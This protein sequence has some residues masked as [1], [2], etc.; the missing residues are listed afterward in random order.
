MPD[1]PQAQDLFDLTGEVA[2]VT[3]ASSGLGARFA[4][5]LAA[6]GARVVLAARRFERIEEHAARLGSAV[7]IRLD[8]T[9]PG[10]L[11]PALDR[12]EAEAGPVSILV[13]NAGITAG[14]A[15]LATEDED[16]RRIMATNVDALWH[17][18]RAFA[19]RRIARQEDG[20]IVNIA[21][22]LGYR[23]SPGVAAYAVSKAAVIQMTQAAAVEFARHR[24]RVNAIAPGYIESEMTQAFLASEKG[25]ETVRRI[26]QRRAGLPSDLDGPLLLLASKKASGFMTGATLAVDGGHMW[27]FQ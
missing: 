21:S 18:T 4:G 13:N 7:A 8:V 23:T 24:I 3:G 20:T 9:Q 11:D 14:A 27:S 6:H 19:R 15:L 5:V 17:L 26:P 1:I 25:R 2:L 10:D 12:A 16:Y 22:I